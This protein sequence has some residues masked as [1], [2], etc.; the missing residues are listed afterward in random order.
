[1][2]AVSFRNYTCILM[3][4]EYTVNSKTKDE[5]T[6]IKVIDLN[7]NQYDKLV[8]RINTQKRYNLWQSISQK[9]NRT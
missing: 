7:I 2:Y 5:I 1:M 8:L 4:E 6:K 9:V 3:A